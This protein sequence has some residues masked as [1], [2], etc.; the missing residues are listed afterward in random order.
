MRYLRLPIDF[1]FI[2]NC[3][4]LLKLFEMMK[5]FSPMYYEEDMDAFIHY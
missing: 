5:S 1:S 3:S 4:T 2:T